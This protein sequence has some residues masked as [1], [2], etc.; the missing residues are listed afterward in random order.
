MGALH[1]Q[2]SGLCSKND[3]LDKQVFEIF[4]LLKV[5][6]DEQSVTNSRFK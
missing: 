2:K 3:K 4:L 1:S 6:S 5:R